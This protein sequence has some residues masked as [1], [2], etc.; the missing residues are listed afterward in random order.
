VS[1]APIAKLEA[2]E[3]QTEKQQRGNLVSIGDAA[4]KLGISFGEVVEFCEAGTLR[5]Q[6]TRNRFWLIDEQS[7]TQWREANPERQPRE[8]PCPRASCEAHWSR[9]GQLVPAFRAGLCRR[10]YSGRP[11]PMKADVDATC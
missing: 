11:L 4:R 1:S 9:R 5:A 6:R 10:C 7:L 8:S 3:S 2:R